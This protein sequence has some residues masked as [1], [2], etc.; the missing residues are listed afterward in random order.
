MGRFEADDPSDPT[1]ERF[2][3]AICTAT[4]PFLTDRDLFSVANRLQ[5][6][7]V[8]FTVIS[9]SCHSGGMDQETDVVAKY[10]SLALGSKLAQNIQS[11]MNTWIPVGISLPTNG[12]VCQGNVSNVTVTDSGHIM[13][14]EDPSQIFV[15]QAK[16]TLI[17]GCR[18]WE[19]S[20]ETDGHG[21]LTKALLD[22]VDSDDFEITYRDLIDALQGNVASAFQNLLPSVPAGYPES[23]TPQLRG[24]TNRVDEGFL[25]PW[26]DSR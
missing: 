24:Q 17:S 18:F 14:D 8:N 22:I 6:S 7:V 20:Y 15:D 1:C 19:L 26:L 25:Q 12:D 5:Q 21:L 2:Y 9:D 16:M 4:R 10:K 23:Q 11:F 3:E 13:C